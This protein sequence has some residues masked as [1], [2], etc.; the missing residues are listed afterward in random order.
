MQ[1]QRSFLTTRPV[2][3]S[4]VFL[5]AVV[6]GYFSYGRLPVNLMP[7]MSYPT[8][9]VRTEYP[10]AAPEEVENDV[11]RPIEEALGVIGGLRRISSVSRAGVSDV[12][13]EFSWGIEMSDA[14]QDTLEKLDLVFLPDE[15]ERPLILRFDPSLDPVMEL[16]LAGRAGS[17]TDEAELRRVRRIAELQVKRALEPIKGVAAV[18]V[19]GGL[20]EEIHVLLDDELLRRTGLSVQNVIDRLRQENINVAGGTLTEGRTEYMVRTLNEYENLQQME[21]TIVATREGRQIRVRDLGRVEWSHKERQITTRTDGRES[22]QLE[23]FKEAD[24]N[25][26]ALA[27]RVKERL[28]DFDPDAP[29]PEETSEPEEDGKEK[30]R[31]AKPSGLVEELY[32]SEGVVLKMVAD[33]S[34]FIEGSVNEVRNTAIIGGLLAIVILFLFLRSLKSTAIIALSI[35][36]SLIVT[37]APL[38]LLGVSLNIMSLGGLALGIGMLVDSSIVVLESIFRCREEG[39]GI[40]EA[41]VRGTNEVRMAVIAS[42]LTSI[43]VFLPMVFVEGVA[44]QAFGDLG[45]AVV[46]SLLAALVVAL[47]LIPMLAS[48]TGAPLLSGERSAPSLLPTASWRAFRGPITEIYRRWARWPRIAWL[49]LPLVLASLWLVVRLILGTALEAVGKLVLGLVMA[50][51]IAWQRYL[52]GPLRHIF[53]FLTGPPLR[54]TS[55]LMDGLGRVYPGAIRWALR[56]S[57]VVVLIVV[58]SMA[59]TGLV[60]V[61]LDSELLPEVHQGELT[62]EVQLPVG[63]PLEETAAV[64][65]P[66]EEAILAERE[67]IDALLLTLGFDPATSQRSDEGEH[68]ARFKLILETSDAR[69]EEAV[70]ARLRRRIERMPDISAR[71]VRPVLFSFQTPI[72][73]EVHGTDLL[74]LRQK[75]EE[76]RDVMA[77]LPELADVETTQRPGAP[78][79]QIVYDRDQLSRYGLNIQ[80]VAQQVRDAVKGYEATLFNLGDRRIPIVVRLQEDDRRRVTDVREFLVNPGGERPIA[81]Y[82]VA[83]VTLAEGPSEVRRVDGRR[84][85]L[86]R[87]NVGM[88]SLGGAVERVESV[89]TR[90]I[91]WP[92]DMTFY[93]AG[94]SQEWDRSRGS[95]LLALALSVF[96]VYVIMAAQFESLVQP[97][98]IMLTIPLAFLGTVLAL[99]LLDISMSVVVFLGMI[100]LA[101]IVVNNAIVLVDYINTLRQRGME[102]VEAIVTAGSVR[103][104]PILMTTATT[105]LGLTPMALGLGDG[106]EIRTPMAI[107]VIS[108]LLA[109][110][111]L[112]LLIIPSFY[113]MID[114]LR[115][116]ALGPSPAATVPEAERLTP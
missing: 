31:L 78:E 5:A 59:L 30:P 3:I 64:L 15:T 9:T 41:A 47:T 36:I 56:H 51:V 81:L 49:F 66:L 68:T 60:A 19:R 32:R 109:S 88:G 116:T 83:E 22:V 85:A 23:V 86:V 91:D 76:T 73:V 46:I 93:V 67:H 99:W 37:F 48:R 14:I 65:A 16:S 33:R 7:E 112:T 98:V 80:T 61:N 13:L 84:V 53:D 95:L 21:D 96:L 82:S 12:V 113:S 114:R 108:G 44:G 10:G 90:E 70:I 25:I 28:G 40:A 6:F 29:G 43:A 74:Q 62:F 8:L 72:E 52:G 11:T 4:M 17:E 26:V 24:A 45:L 20:E 1:N 69:A 97:L 71:V 75:A 63:T 94:Q 104:R 58:G 54:V 77:A 107:T 42:T 106:A 27:G 87:S 39:D 102:R 50:I 103:L 111:V 89:L 35:P 18:R 115:E 2:A 105:A 100:M 101:G 38:Q 55:T 34:L 57:V 79:V 110:T 92:S